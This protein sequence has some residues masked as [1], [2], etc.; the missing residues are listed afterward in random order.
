MVGGLVG[1]IIVI[2]LI[3]LICYCCMK[4]RGEKSSR[5]SM[6]YMCMIIDRLLYMYL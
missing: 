5:A 3:I 6:E 4:K 2:V 1:A